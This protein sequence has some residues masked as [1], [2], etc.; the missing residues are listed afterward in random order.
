[1]C[2]LQCKCKAGDRLALERLRCR[3]YR[4]GLNMSTERFKM[5]VSGEAWN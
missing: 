5:I 3:L 4:R 1:M 2:D